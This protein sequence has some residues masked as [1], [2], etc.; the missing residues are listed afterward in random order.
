MYSKCKNFIT[1]AEELKQE[2]QEKS[3]KTTQRHKNYPATCE[4]ESR[5]NY[6]LIAMFDAKWADHIKYEQCDVY[7]VECAQ[8]PRNEDGSECEVKLVNID[9]WYNLGSSPNASQLSRL[10][11]LLD[12]CTAPGAVVLIMPEDGKK[13]GR[14]SLTVT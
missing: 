6:E 14:N 5:Q 11:R 8:L 7:S 2:V 13:V 1:G 10:R 4:A 12:A 3:G 9:P